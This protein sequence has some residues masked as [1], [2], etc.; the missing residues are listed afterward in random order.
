MPKGCAQAALSCGFY[1]ASRAARQARSSCSS[2]AMSWLPY[3]PAHAWCRRGVASSVR[4]RSWRAPAGPIRVRRAGEEGAGVRVLFPDGAE[5]R[6]EPVLDPPA[7]SHRAP[8]ALARSHTF[9]ESA[10]ARRS[11]R[12][13]RA[14]GPSRPSA[15]AALRAWSGSSTNS[16]RSVGS[17][18]SASPSSDQSAPAAATAH[19]P[20]SSSRRA[21]IAS[22]ASGP[23]LPSASAIARTSHSG[24][25]APP[26]PV[27][28]PQHL[29]HRRRV[30]QPA[31]REQQRRRTVVGVECVEGDLAEP[32]AQQWSEC[33]RGRA[34][35]LGFVTGFGNAARPSAQHLGERRH[36]ARIAGSGERLERGAES[37]RLPTG[38]SG[39]RGPSP[40]GRP[41]GRRPGRPDRRVSPG[42]RPRHRAAAAPRRRPV[43]RSTRPALRR[44]P[45]IHA[46]APPPST[47]RCTG[48]PYRRCSTA[49]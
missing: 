32:L 31:E 11:G 48:R 8:V 26:A 1:A 38:V 36:R 18:A 34:Q 43:R 6:G 17:T 22:R 42:R 35:V 16:L 37:R 29:R 28:Q 12:A 2:S 30:S 13:G 25:A 39:A 15:S 33:G 23:H 24:S 27:Q 49:P 44:S 14:A 40:P 21:G 5:H 41:G 4:R 45:A 20:S 47:R 46:T 3:P 7:M 10:M 9:P 19:P